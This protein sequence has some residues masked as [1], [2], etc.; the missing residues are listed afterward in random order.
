MKR[1]IHVSTGQVYGTARNAKIDW[2]HPHQ[3]QSSYNTFKICAE[4]IPLSYFNLHSMSIV[5]ARSIKTY[6][7]WQFN[8]AVTLNEI[9]KIKQFK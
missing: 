5:I 6:G 9:V 8:R 3:T 2:E 4:T 1:I 7:S